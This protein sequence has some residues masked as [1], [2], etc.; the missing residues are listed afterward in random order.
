[1]QIKTG[2]GKS[3]T[4]AVLS[5][6]FALCDFD[7]RCAC[8][9]VYLSKRDY[10]AFSGIFSQLELKDRIQYS[11]FNEICEMEI[12]RNGEL[13]D[14]VLNL[15]LETPET[16][17]T[18]KRE[19]SPRPQ[20]LLIDEVDVFFSDDFFGKVY[21]PQAQIKG[22]AISALTDYMWEN[23][24]RPMT[25]QEVEATDEYKDA[26][27]LYKPDY[28]FLLQEAVK[29]MIIDVKG[30]ESYQMGKLMDGKI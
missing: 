29:Q 8:Y 27:Q 25:I 19:A 10:N 13:R 20:V 9:S 26:C 30:V 21:Q 5:I 23:R 4:L 17:I 24:D 1:M 14:I 2:E 7:V 18:V 28:Q 16:T 11:T 15:I 12:N 6:I 22:A 3:V